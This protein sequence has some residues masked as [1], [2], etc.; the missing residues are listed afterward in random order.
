MIPGNETGG[1]LQSF[2][3]GAVQAGGF[4]ST[5]V[6]GAAG[7]GNVSMIHNER[8]RFN[9]TVMPTLTWRHQSPGWNADLGFGYSSATDDNHDVGQ[10]YFRAV[11]AIRRALTISFD[12]VTYL[13][14]G[15]ITVR[16]AA[17]V[18]QNPYSINGYALTSAAS[19]QNATRDT[20]K[21]AY[22]NVGR[23]LPKMA[24]SRQ[25]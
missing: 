20:Q 12:D 16:N 22:G 15:T 24:S 3:P 14:P 4:S 10:G 2:N 1:L 13:R 19:Q 5:F 17:G 8:N 11:N 25:S 21:T 23:K 7:A 6:R 18:D 9:R